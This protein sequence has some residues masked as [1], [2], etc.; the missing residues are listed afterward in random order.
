MM[1]VI[2][3]P[4]LFGPPELFGRSQNVWEIG[5]YLARAKCEA[6]IWCR[7]SLYFLRVVLVQTTGKVFVFHVPPRA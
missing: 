3:D 1:P 5:R 7:P 6:G 4:Q 2:F